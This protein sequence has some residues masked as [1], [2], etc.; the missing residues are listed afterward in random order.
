MQQTAGHATTGAPENQEPQPPGAFDLYFVAMVVLFLFIA[1]C[2]LQHRS[3]SAYGLSLVSVAAIIATPSLFFNSVFNVIVK[4]EL[5][6]RLAASVRRISFALCIIGGILILAFLVI[7]G[8]EHVIYGS[9]PL[10]AVLGI[11][12]ALIFT[13]GTI[14][15]SLA[16]IIGIGTS[17]ESGDSDISTLRAFWDSLLEIDKANLRWF[18]AGT[19]FLIG[20]L[21]QFSSTT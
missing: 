11:A 1:D 2:V 19:L 16:F 15:L 14:G 6:T 20:T 8:H 13:F 21:L 18:F 12:G 10:V 17:P 7:T 4:T 9:K 3:D 5:R